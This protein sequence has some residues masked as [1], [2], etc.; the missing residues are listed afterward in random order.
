LLTVPPAEVPSRCGLLARC[1]HVSGPGGQLVNGTPQTGR[2]EQ[3]WQLMPS[4][5]WASG[6]HQLIVDPVLEDLAGNS[7]RRVFTVG[8]RP[9]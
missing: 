6:L 3:S 4:R 2:G 1:L 5:A 7:V 8:F 9:R